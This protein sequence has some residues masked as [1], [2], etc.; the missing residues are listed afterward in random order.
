MARPAIYKTV[1]V[2]NSQGRVWIADC[3]G[4]LDLSV[5]NDAEGVVERINRRF[6]GY[7]IFYRDSMGNW[8]ELLHD[9]D[10]FRGFAPA[11]DIAA[12][13]RGLG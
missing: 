4:P 12:Q 5:T 8:D 2:D 7:R 1:K 6:P 3:G 13:E 9:A 10:R 11:R